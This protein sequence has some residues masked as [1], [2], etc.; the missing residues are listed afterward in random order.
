MNNI[1]QYRKRFYNLMEST[2]GNVKPL[3]N[4]GI[5]P[6]QNQIVVA[7]QGC[8]NV[9]SLILTLG[10]KDENGRIIV[11]N[12][13]I[14]K[15]DESGLSLITPE[16]VQSTQ[17]DEKCPAPSYYEQYLKGKTRQ[18]NT[19]QYDRDWYNMIYT[20]DEINQQKWYV[21]DEDRVKLGQ[22]APEKEVKT[23]QE[24]GTEVETTSIDPNSIV[25]SS[26]VTKT[27]GFKVGQITGEVPQPTTDT[28]QKAAETTQ[29]TGGFQLSQ[30]AKINTTND[31]AFDYALDNGKY[32]FKGKGS[33]TKKYP[34]WKEAKGNALTSIQNKV[35]F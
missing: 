6:Q 1:E 22:Y 7:F 9:G 25:P 29:Q 23:S 17:G 24:S 10:E 13:E 32:Y 2:I 11:D 28:T 8:G 20:F 35:K 26:G 31:K 15:S 5:S 19:I 33:Y 16:E 27:Q 12:V 3:I 18:I 14:A 21:S 30:D 34:N 4:E